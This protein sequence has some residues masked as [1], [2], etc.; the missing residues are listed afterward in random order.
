LELLAR[1]YYWPQQR[2]YVHRY[3]DNCDTCKRIKPIRHAPFGLLRHLQLPSRPWDS[4]S[5]DFI[6]GVLEVDGCNALWVIVDRLTEMAHFVACKETMGA[7][8]LAD[9]FLLHVVWAHGLPNS[10]I[11]DRGSLFTSLFWKQIMT[12][13]GTSRNL[14]TAF[15][16][17]TDGQTERT[18]ATL[19]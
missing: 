11:S 1:K 17:E 9:E 8:D 5:M 18:N 4:R 15:H 6:T 2:Q 10:I 7:K 14:S 13:L 19:E 12:A 16:P 3:V